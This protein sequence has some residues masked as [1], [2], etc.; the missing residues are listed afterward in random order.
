MKINHRWHSFSLVELVVVLAVMGIIL[1]AGLFAFGSAQRTSR[2]QER[3]LMVSKLVTIVNDYF[4][5]TSSYPQTNAVV[6]GTASV[7]V[8]GTPVT[9]KGYLS[10]SATETNASRTRY[11]YG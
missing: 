6:W 10:Y 7:S 4:R 5:T 2:D 1:A 3:K 11:F 9:L 8:A